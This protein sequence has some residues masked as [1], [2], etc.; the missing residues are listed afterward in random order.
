LTFR[1]TGYIGPAALIPDNDGI[2]LHGQVQW[3]F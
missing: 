1:E 2:G 3:K